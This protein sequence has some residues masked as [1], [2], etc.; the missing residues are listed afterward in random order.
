MR[1]VKLSSKKKMRNT[2]F[3][4]FLLIS[5]LITRI[6]YIQFV[7]GGELTSM[8]YQQQTLDRKINPKRGTIYDTTREKCTS[9]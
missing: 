2:L 7:Q 8:A 1:P 9:C 5:G 3:I 6:G 4:A